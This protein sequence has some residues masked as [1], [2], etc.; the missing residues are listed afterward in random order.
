VDKDGQFV[1]IVFRSQQETKTHEASL[2]NFMTASVLGV[3][4]NLQNRIAIHGNGVVLGGHAIAFGGISGR[5]KSTLTAYCLSQ[6]AG[7]VTDDVFTVDG[8]GHALPGYSRIKLLPETAR[9]FGLTV[10]THSYK[11][12]YCPEDLGGYS[13]RKSLPLRTIYLLEQSEDGKIEYKHVPNSEALFELIAYSY[14]ARYFIG[15]SPIL[16]DAYTDLVKQVSVRR[17]CYP[18]DFTRLPEV[19]AFLLEQARDP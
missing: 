6:G 14:Y 15:Q 13:I 8:S 18:R 2:I 16:F 11:T 4:L 9:R 12:H 1:E 17:L 19:Y 7:L 5:G 3:C 10:A